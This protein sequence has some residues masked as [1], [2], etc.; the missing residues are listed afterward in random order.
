MN[1]NSR[2][3]ESITETIKMKYLINSRESG[4]NFIMHTLAIILITILTNYLSYGEFKNL[5]ICRCD[6]SGIYKYIKNLFKKRNVFILEGKLTLK[7]TDYFTRTDRLFSDRFV[8][9]WHYI[10]TNSMDNPDITSFKEYAETCNIFDEHGD[11]KSSRRSRK[12]FDSN[13]NKNQY[14]SQDI[15]IVNQSETFNLTSDIMC[16]VKFDIEKFEDKKT[17]TTET[18]YIELSSYTLTNQEILDFLDQIDYEYKQEVEAIRFNKRFIYTLVGNSNTRGGGDYDEP[19]NTWDECEFNSTRTFNNIFFEQKTRL[20]DKLDFFEKNRAWY[21]YE[22]HPYTFGIG[23]HGPPGTGKTSIIKSIANHMKRHIIVIPLS[24]IKT[25]TE[26]TEYFFENR[27]NRFN[28]ESIGF[29]KKIIVFE[30][31]DCMSDIVKQRTLTNKTKSKNDT[32]VLSDTNSENAFTSVESGDEKEEQVRE[33]KKNTIMQTRLLNKI[34]KK[35][36][37][38]HDE[39]MVFN[40]DK[41]KDDKITLSFILNIIDGLRETPGRILIITSND[42]NSLDSALTRPGRIDLTLEMKNASIDVIKQMYLHYYG[43]KI[44]EHVVT[45]L[46]DYKLSHAKIVNLRLEHKNGADFLAALVKEF[47]V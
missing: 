3:V 24:K 20:L 45:R 9:F 8:A 42:Y 4:D 39:N 7:N 14:N 38:D 29:D 33:T 46:R 23:L 28:N 18:I 32:E 5:S 26:F 10:N 30:D 44:P 43:E 1:L 13:N 34:A 40:F 41:D 12:N 37:E 22:G 31:I 35:I 21:E 11:S 47:H 6:L 2:T 17:T 19:K 36:D 16:K 27:Y 15:F 25:Q